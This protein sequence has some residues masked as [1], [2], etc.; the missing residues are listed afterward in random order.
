VATVVHV[1]VAVPWNSLEAGRWN[2]LAVW[3]AAP[4]ILRLLGAALG[5]APFTATGTRWSAGVRLALVMAVTGLVAPVVVAVVLGVAAALVVGSILAGHFRGIDRMLAAL[6]IGTLGTLLLHL[7]WAVDLIT[8]GSDLPEVWS[9]VVGA[10]P[11][12]PGA[13]GFGEILRFDTG[14]SASSVLTWLLVVGAAYPLLLGKGWRLAWAT[15]WWTVAAAGWTWVWLVERGSI[16]VAAPAHEVVLGVVSACLAGC[17]ALG[18]TVFGVDLREHHFGWRQ[19]VSVLA[20]VGVFVGLLPMVGASFGGRW[21]TPS[22][23]IAQAAA[24]LDDEVEETPF[25]VAWIGTEAAVAGGWPVFDEVR[26]QVTPSGIPE[27]G[28]VL[29]S[30]PTPRSDLLVEALEAAFAGRTSRLGH[31]LGPLGIRYLV[32]QL[33][34][35]PAPYELQAP[36]LPGRVVD[37]L[38][39]QLDLTT[40]IVDPTLLVFEN[41]AWVGMR[42]EAEV[43]HDGD[44]SG[45]V[46]LDQV[47]I[48][49]AR[50]VLADDDGIAAW[51]GRVSGDD[52]FIAEDPAAA[53]QLEVGGRTV[54]GESVAGAAVVFRQPGGGDARLSVSGAGVRWLVAGAQILLWLL[55]LLAVGRTRR[56]VWQDDEVGS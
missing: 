36:E 11:A 22:R 15:R 18:V 56:S 33:E 4:W 24:F 39:R 51:T 38:T 27:V 30:V 14:S 37:G 49:G 3:A 1:A 50:P 13:L 45:L 53:W 54:D 8:G 52:V 21:A 31:L 16:S 34:A 44:G 41:S 42:A 23:D 46:A 43:T 9:M 20:L 28:D 10:R 29:P 40:R 47:V 19:I 32:V 25:R 7:P 6:A 5:S 55:V 35:A 26:V 17:A 48:E 2:G 12:G